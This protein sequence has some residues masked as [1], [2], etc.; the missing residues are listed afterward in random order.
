MHLREKK[1][2]EFLISKLFLYKKRCKISWFVTTKMRLVGE[3][4]DIKFHQI[5]SNVYRC[6]SENLKCR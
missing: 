6:I 5:M 2:C 4:Q 1:T 3:K